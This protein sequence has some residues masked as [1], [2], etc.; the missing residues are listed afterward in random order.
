MLPPVS[1]AASLRFASGIVRA[2]EAMVHRGEPL[3]ELRLVKEL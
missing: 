1:T 3:H 2:M